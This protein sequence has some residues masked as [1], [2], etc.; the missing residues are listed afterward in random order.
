MLLTR[1]S[2]RGR[3]RT[4]HRV[5]ELIRISVHGIV[6]N[7]GGL[8]TVYDKNGTKLQFVDEA[9]IDGRMV[10]RIYQNSRPIL[11]YQLA[12]K[13]IGGQIKNQRNW[14]A[15]CQYYVVVNGR[16]YSYLYVDTKNRTVGTK[17]CFGAL[18]TSQSISPK[19]KDEWRE[20]QKRA[21]REVSVPGLNR[22]AN[23]S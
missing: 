15:D 7:R 9:E 3:K 16:R 4:R 19:Q 22:S 11:T 6:T 14:W 13:P 2:P 8:H 5:E 23:D 1:L 21:K 20:H 17:D 10:L 18:W 12:E